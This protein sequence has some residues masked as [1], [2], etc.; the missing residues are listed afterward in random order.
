MAKKDETNVPQEENVV[1]EEKEE[2]KVKAFFK[3]SW[4]VFAGVL[5]GGIAVGAGLYL[6]GKG[7]NE[8]AEVV[9]TATP[10]VVGTVS[11][12]VGTVQQ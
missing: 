12:V 7:H 9:S 10:E 3:K 5:V 1:V 11:E 6:Y 4:K 2:S 8:I